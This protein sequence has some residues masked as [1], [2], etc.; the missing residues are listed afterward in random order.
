VSH[1]LWHDHSVVVA[2]RQLDEGRRGRSTLSHLPA[3]AC[4]ACAWTQDLHTLPQV[5]C[6][7]PRPNLHLRDGATN[8][9]VCVQSQVPRR[10]LYRCVHRLVRRRPRS[11]EPVSE[12][13]R[14]IC[15]RPEP[16]VHPQAH[17]QPGA[18]QDFQATACE[19]KTHGPNTGP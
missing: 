13:P 8:H 19:V 16:V 6:H 4:H 18:R 9:S 3:S 17:G 7:S 14:C 10:S 15:V 5:R 2:D 11:H 12:R 1:D